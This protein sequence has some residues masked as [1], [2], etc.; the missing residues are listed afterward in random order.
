MFFNLAFGAIFRGIVDF[1]PFCLST[2]LNSNC[3]YSGIIFLYSPLYFNLRAQR[4]RNCLQMG[5]ISALVD[6]CNLTRVARDLWAKTGE[7]I[8]KSGYSVG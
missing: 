8:G 3:P 2:V 6:H 4:S 1:L 7:Q 5:P